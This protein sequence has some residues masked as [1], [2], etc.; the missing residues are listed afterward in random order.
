M[1]SPPR[2]SQ[3]NPD[4]GTKVHDLVYTPPKKKFARKKD[5]GE[6]TYVGNTSALCHVGCLCILIQAANLIGDT[7]QLHTGW[8]VYT[9]NNFLFLG[10]RL[11]LSL[12]FKESLSF[13]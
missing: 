9:R 10:V 11:V 8:T 7:K 3:Q 2:L 5:G 6:R 13:R 4:C 1:L 12:F